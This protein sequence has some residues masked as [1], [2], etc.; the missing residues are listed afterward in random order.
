M[1]KKYNI[2][3]F[4]ETQYKTFSDNW[5]KE[6]FKISCKANE[7]QRKLSKQIVTKYKISGICDPCYIANLICLYPDWINRLFFCYSICIKKVHNRKQYKKF[8]GGLK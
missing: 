7:S 8:V 1:K 6:C 2:K 5:F 3:D 4:P